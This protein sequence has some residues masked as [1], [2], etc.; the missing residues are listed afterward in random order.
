MPNPCETNQYIISLPIIYLFLLKTPIIRPSYLLQL[1][2]K[3][4]VSSARVV[5]TTIN[6]VVKLTTGHLLG[7]Y[8]GTQAVHSYRATR[9]RY[10]STKVL[11]CEFL[12]FN[13]VVLPL[14][15]RTYYRQYILV[16]LFMCSIFIGI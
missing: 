9:R 11:T 4:L 14:M 15:H 3:L 12:R 1:T 16:F 7:Q 8:Y 2:Q 10:I 5:K 6:V 13:S